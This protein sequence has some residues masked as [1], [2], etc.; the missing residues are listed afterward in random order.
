MSGDTNDLNVIME[1]LPDFKKLGLKYND[2]VGSNNVFLLDENSGE[3]LK[4]SVDFQSGTAAKEWVSVDN[5][6]VEYS[7]RL[8]P[9]IFEY[10]ASLPNA[11]GMF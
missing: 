7:S 2:N 3:A 5:D 9:Q 4:K 6:H 8:Q 1:H 10:H 11:M